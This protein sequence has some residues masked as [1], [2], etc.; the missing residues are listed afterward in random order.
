MKKLKRDEYFARHGVKVKDMSEV[1]KSLKLLH[2]FV[3]CICLVVVGVQ[4]CGF[5][6][7]EVF[8]KYIKIEAD[9]YGIVGTT[10]RS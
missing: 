4:A 9:S 1:P 5:S 10:R 2:K 8:A 3:A 6:V 7:D